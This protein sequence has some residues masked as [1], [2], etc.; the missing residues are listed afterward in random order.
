MR[1]AG[2]ERAVSELMG[3]IL[4]VAVLMTGFSIISVMLLSVPPPTSTEKAILG[5]K[6]AWCPDDKKFDI[7]I[8][9]EGGENLSLHN[10]KFILITDGNASHPFTPQS[11][12]VPSDPQYYYEPPVTC[13]DT[14]GLASRLDWADADVLTAGESIKYSYWP[15]GGIPVNLTHILIQEPSTIGYAPVSQLRISYVQNMSMYGSILGTGGQPVSEGSYFVTP[16]YKKS[17]LTYA[18]DGCEVDFM[19]T[20]PGADADYGWG[21]RGQPWNYLETFNNPPPI[22]INP[23]PPQSSFPTD[24]NT[25]TVMRVKFTGYIEY[26]LGYR[27]AA[28]TCNERIIDYLKR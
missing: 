1:P 22:S 26:R 14:I 7:L 12:Y 16:S 10:L 24:D 25:T 2:K 23:Y 13:N 4:L 9:H 17:T 6:C 11:V 27:T 21:S 15:P 3:A 28:I 5:I 8:D 19:Y 18:A 20:N